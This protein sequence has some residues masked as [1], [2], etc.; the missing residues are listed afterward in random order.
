M[1]CCGSHSRDEPVPSRAQ[2]APRDE[3]AG[4]RL[5]PGAEPKPLIEHGRREPTSRIC[6]GAAGTSVL[7]VP[8]Y[9]EVSQREGIPAVPGQPALKIDHNSARPDI[10]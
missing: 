3:P 2:R 8:D 5:A 6:S 1:V 10:R 4:C 9:S 7:R